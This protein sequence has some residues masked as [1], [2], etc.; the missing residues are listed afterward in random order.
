[1]EP[2]GPC[3]LD[4]P[5]CLDIDFR[6]AMNVSESQWQLRFI[7]DL[8]YH[9]T[10]VELELESQERTVNDEI[11]HVELKTAGL[12]LLGLPESALE[13]LGILEARLAGSDGA[14]LALVR[15]VTDVRRSGNQWQRGILDPFR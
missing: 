14:Q 6:T 13:S 11:H 5:L 1:M 12:P 15:L 8:V 3:S 2:H 9:Q 7:A 10:P 4:A